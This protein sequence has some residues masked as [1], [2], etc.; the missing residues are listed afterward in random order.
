VAI[1]INTKPYCET[2]QKIADILNI[3]L[4]NVISFTVTCA[5]ESLIIIK[6]EYYFTEK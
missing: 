5:K 1:I 6:K 2:C 3:D 4:E